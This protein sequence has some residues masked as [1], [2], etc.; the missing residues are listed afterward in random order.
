MKQLKNLSQTVMMTAAVIYNC[1]NEAEFPLS[2]SCSQTSIYLW[3][4]WVVA[5]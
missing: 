3:K 5:T 1:A 4:P 2:R